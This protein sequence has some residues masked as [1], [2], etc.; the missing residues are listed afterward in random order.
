MGIK[1]GTV[2]RNLSDALSRLADLLRIEGNID[3]QEGDAS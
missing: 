1:T 2:S 3:I